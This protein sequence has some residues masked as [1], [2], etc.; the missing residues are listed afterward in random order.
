MLRNK[1]ENQLSFAEIEERRE[2]P[3]IPVPRAELTDDYLMAEWR[4]RQ[5]EQN[6]WE[7]GLKTT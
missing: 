3:T 7:Q 2:R 6:Q 5:E 4:Q 1:V